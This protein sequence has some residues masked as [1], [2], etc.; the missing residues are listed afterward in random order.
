MGQKIDYDEGVAEVHAFVDGK[1][2]AIAEA[3]RAYELKVE[4][5]NRREAECVIP[6]SGK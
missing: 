4:G 1:Y 6:Y 3:K 2:K 5:I